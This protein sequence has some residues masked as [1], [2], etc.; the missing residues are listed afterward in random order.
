MFLSLNKKKK[1]LDESFLFEI[2][3]NSCKLNVWTWIQNNQEGQGVGCVCI[4]I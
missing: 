1:F 2:Y 4:F 3:W